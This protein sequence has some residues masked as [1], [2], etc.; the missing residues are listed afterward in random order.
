M[1]QV[2]QD[3]FKSQKIKSQQLRVEAISER[4]KRLKKLRF[5]IL[6]NKP[7]IREALLADLKKSATEVDIVEIFTVTS[8]LNKAITNLTDWSRPKRV[9][10][11]MTY[12]GTTGFRQP[13]AKGVC[14]I[15]APWNFPFQ[16]VMAPLVSCIAAGNTAILKPSENTPATSR[17]ISEMVKEIFDSN[18]VT[19]VE[20]AV[21]ETT[22]LLEMPFDHIFFTGST[23][24]GKIIMK[25]ASNHLTSV[26]LELGGKSPTIID[27]SANIDDA[28]K[29]IAWG[30]FFNNGQTCIAPD[31]IL[32]HE[33]KK[34]EFIK[35][36]KKH[37]SSIFDSESKGFQ[38][39]EDYNRIVN[40]KHAKR[41][42]E[43][44]DEATNKDGKLAHGGIH[45]LDQRFIEPTIIS[46]ADESAKISQ[47]EIF[48]P[49][50]PVYTFTDITKVIDKI[51]QGDK[52]L[53]LYLF[54][55]TKSTQR[56]ITKATT[57]GSMAINDVV[58]QFTHPNLPFGG[59]NQSGMGKSHGY[60]GF[61][62]FSN[63]KSV[64]K[65]RVG[66]T[67]AMMFYPPYGSFKKWVVSLLIKWL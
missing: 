52:P 65:Q 60:D 66:F 34:E 12:L 36:I 37:L 30:K 61:I 32:V 15:I 18:V 55:K 26:T 62:E 44:I 6:Q 13:E 21:D 47:E 14:L 45:D 59:V 8:E 54:S 4:K 31:Y 39:T 20:G 22:W 48:G 41:L 10:P 7:R 58:I 40:K 19:V 25:A 38:S 9:S 33:S 51:N 17:L 5:W 1:R 57:S 24:V 3:L 23:A 56:M 11:G 49:I 27:E 63:E 64:L 42:I 50:L 43:L 29:K 2:I 35:C 46:D 53:A 67:M 28:A 16:L